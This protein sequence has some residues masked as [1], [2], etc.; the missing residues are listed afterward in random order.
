MKDPTG[1]LGFMRE[2]IM[3]YDYTT[4]NSGMWWN[5]AND[6]STLYSPSSFR[7]LGDY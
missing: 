2:K 3:M 6:G 4:S 1:E 5:A 7:E